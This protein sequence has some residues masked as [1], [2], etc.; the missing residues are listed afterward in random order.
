MQTAILRTSLVAGIR[1]QDDVSAKDMMVSL[2]RTLGYSV[3]NGGM[4]TALDRA[5]GAFL[6]TFKASKSTP[7]SLHNMKYSES[8]KDNME[9]KE[10]KN[11]QQREYSKNS[12]SSYNGGYNKSKRDISHFIVSEGTSAPARVASARIQSMAAVKDI[13]IV[14]FKPS[15]APSTGA[16]NDV[17]PSDMDT[18]S[19]TRYSIRLCYTYDTILTCYSCIDKRGSQIMFVITLK[20]MLFIT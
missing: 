15:D 18:T 14:Q 13:R 10:R 5:L 12:K 1:V 9:R 4:Q 17:F 3:V 19:D 6:D 11:S 20:C 7:H 2:N 8:S 16:F